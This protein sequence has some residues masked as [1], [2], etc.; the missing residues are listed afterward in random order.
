MIELLVV[1]VMSF[2][3]IFVFPLL[4]KVRLRGMHE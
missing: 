4:K 1:T 2:D 3:A